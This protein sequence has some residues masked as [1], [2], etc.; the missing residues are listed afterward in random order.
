M[1]LVKKQPVAVAVNT[2]TCVLQYKSGIL[3]QN[4]CDCTHEHYVEVDTDYMF[5][6][7]GYGQTKPE[8]K[9]FT[10]CSGYWLLRSSF[11]ALWGDKGFMKLCIN[12]NRPSDI[13]GTCNIL[14][15]PHL[16]EVGIK[17]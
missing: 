2:P 15:Y 12:R 17:A 6:L 1:A 5:T 10:Y 8:D 4:D 14:V 7:V 11:G 3:S 9:E 13:I 16:P